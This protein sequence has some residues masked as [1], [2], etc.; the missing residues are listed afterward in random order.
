ME[1]AKGDEGDG[2]V[3]KTKYSHL[4]GCVSFNMPHLLVADNK[5]RRLYCIPPSSDVT[6]LHCICG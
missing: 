4:L 5:P 3:D 2:L 1:V 6:S